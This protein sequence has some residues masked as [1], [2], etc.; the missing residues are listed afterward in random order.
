MAIRR[1]G[2]ARRGASIAEATNATKAIGAATRKTEPYH[3]TDEAKERLEFFDRIGPSPYA[4][5]FGQ[6]IAIT[7]SELLNYQR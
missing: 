5:E 6:Q 7:T 1:I 3:L 2:R 4:F